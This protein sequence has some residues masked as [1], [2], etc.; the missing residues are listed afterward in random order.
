MNNLLNHSIKINNMIFN[1]NRWISNGNNNYNKCK[2]GRR[3][4]SNFTYNKIKS[5]SNNKA[6]LNHLNHQNLLIRNYSY[7]KSLKNHLNQ[8]HINLGNLN[9]H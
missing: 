3:R 9:Y 2:I 1:N 5:L 6:H 4:N 7:L 8:N